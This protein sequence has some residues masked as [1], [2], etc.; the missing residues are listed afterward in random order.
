MRRAVAVAAWRPHVTTSA[1]AAPRRASRRQTGAQHRR[2]SSTASG[3]R[4]MARP[5]P[6]ACAAHQ[7]ALRLGLLRR[8][9]RSNSFEASCFCYTCAHPAIQP[10]NSSSAC[11]QHAALRR[12]A[13]VCHS[14]MGD[15]H[16]IDCRGSTK[17]TVD[18]R[19]TDTD[20]HILHPT[21]GKGVP[22]RLLG[23]SVHTPAAAITSCNTPARH[24]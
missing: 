9:L 13:S 14:K 23:R 3:E 10:K 24:S 12:F 20:T 19:A 7:Q 2:R 1:G 8:H 15:T 16:Y 5:V 4:T 17:R 22:C 21:H 18:E 11:V 6:A